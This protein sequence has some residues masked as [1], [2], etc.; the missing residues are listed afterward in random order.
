M[1]PEKLQVSSPDKKYV[2]LEIEQ[3]RKPSMLRRL[4]NAVMSLR[5]RMQIRKQEQLERRLNSVE[6]RQ[7]RRRSNKRLEKRR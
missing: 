1:N 5:E 6:N 3:Q 7:R 2:Q 4:G